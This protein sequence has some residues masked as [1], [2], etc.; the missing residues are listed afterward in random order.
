MWTLQHRDICTVLNALL[1]ILTQR[2]FPWR[3]LWT[4]CGL[5]SCWHRGIPELKRGSPLR[6]DMHLLSNERPNNSVELRD[7][8]HS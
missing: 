5:M 8:A 6:E 1:S 7:A 3:Q 2:A 4:S